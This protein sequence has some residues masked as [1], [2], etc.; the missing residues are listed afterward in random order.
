MCSQ[1]A[2]AVAEAAIAVA[3]A[4]R[5]ESQDVT[6]IFA[7][8]GSIGLGLAGAIYTK[9]EDFCTKTAQFHTRNDG[10]STNNDGFYR[11]HAR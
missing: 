10:I 3:E 11:G 2:T 1:E 4:A 6:V 8:Q 9:H 7:E 5:D